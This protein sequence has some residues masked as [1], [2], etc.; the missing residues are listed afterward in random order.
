[1]EHFNALVVLIW[2]LW[3]LVCLFIIRVAIPGLVNLH[4]DGAL[5]LALVLGIAVPV[6]GYLLHISVLNLKKE[7]N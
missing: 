2:T 1:V 5:I 4:N 3:V 7:Q 6:S